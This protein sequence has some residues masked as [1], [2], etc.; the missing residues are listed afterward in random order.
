MPE[1]YGERGRRIDLAGVVLSAAGLVAV[2]YGIVEA[3]EKG[4]GDPSSF[5][6]ITAGVVALLALALWQRRA[7]APLIDLDLF[8]SRGFTGGA[9]LATVAS[10][11][12]FGLLFAL[13]QFFQ[14]VSGQDAFGTGLRLLPVIG[15][16]LVGARWSAP[17]SPTS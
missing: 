16:L 1:S 14:A 6:T 9:V 10:F 17:G 12:F 7:K 13:P 3:G 15:G 5:L 11:A 4:I 8:R 2:T